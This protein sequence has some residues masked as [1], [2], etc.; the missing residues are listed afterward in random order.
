M[1]FQEWQNEFDQKKW[2]DSIIA[3]EDTCGSY[4]FCVKCN[5][6]EENPCARAFSRFKNPR[7]RIAI[8]RPRV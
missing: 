8:L 2:I 3:G 4:E 5:K 7:I 1:S 6:D